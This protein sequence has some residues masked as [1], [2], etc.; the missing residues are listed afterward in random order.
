VGHCD[1][2]SGLLLAA[3]CMVCVGISSIM[4]L[5]LRFQPALAGR[6]KM[7]ET[8]WKRSDFLLP[9]IEYPQA[10]S[11]MTLAD[12]RQGNGKPVSKRLQCRSGSLRRSKTQLVNIAPGQYRLAQLLGVVFW[13]AK[14]N[15]H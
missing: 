5:L 7:I 4:R 2:M 3:L 14:I 11:G 10:L 12:T 9:G 1:F 8:R 13:Q 15:R 6:P